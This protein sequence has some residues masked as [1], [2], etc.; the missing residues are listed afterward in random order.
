MTNTWTALL[1]LA[2]V[3]LATGCGHKKVN[4]EEANKKLDEKFTPRLGLAKKAELVEYFGKPEWCRSAEGTGGESCRFF[5]KT[6]TAWTGEKRD[7]KA[8]TQ[9]EEVTCDFDAGGILR[10]L[11]TNAQK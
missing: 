4:S 10:K 11:E 3:V 9:Y 6:G 2:I 8:H 7:K 5:K 1:T